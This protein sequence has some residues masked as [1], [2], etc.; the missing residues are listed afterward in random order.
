MTG[1]QPGYERMATG[2][3]PDCLQVKGL[4]KDGMIASHSVGEPGQRTKCPGVGFPP[5]TGD[6]SADSAD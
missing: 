4:R 6:P 5:E 1:G 2:V 3:C